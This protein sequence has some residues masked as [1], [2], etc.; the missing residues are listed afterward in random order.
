M[1]MIIAWIEIF[2]TSIHF[3][4]SLLRIIDIDKRQPF[5]DIII[6]YSLNEHER[7]EKSE[8]KFLLHKMKWYKKIRDHFYSTIWA[9]FE[10]FI[11]HFTAIK[12]LWSKIKLNLIKNKIKSLTSS[13]LHIIWLNFYFIHFL[14]Y[15]DTKKRSQKLD[16]RRWKRKLSHQKHFLL[17][18]KLCTR[19]KNVMRCCS[20]VWENIWVWDDLRGFYLFH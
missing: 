5:M 9:V 2:N 14:F 18:F 1:M 19:E 12:L 11:P 4:S 3:C 6:H 20:K 15:K 7:E 8:R 10:K 16:D 17:S 13:S